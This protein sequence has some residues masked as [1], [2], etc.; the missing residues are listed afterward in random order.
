MAMLHTVNK[1]PFEK[2]TLD[3]CLRMARSGSAILLIEDA[4]YAAMKGTV[5]EEKV[6]AGNKKCR[7]YALEPDLKARGLNR[8]DCIE[9][10]ELVDYDGFVDLAV[11]H[12]K[13][14]AWL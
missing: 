13:V 4:V 9:G 2:R 11:T 5:I 10:I 3:S 14:Q 12:D 8:A 1:S 6:R 7:I